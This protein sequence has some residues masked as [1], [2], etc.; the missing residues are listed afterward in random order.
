LLLFEVLTSLSFVSV[1]WVAGIRPS[2]NLPNFQ[3]VAGNPSFAVSKR[4]F[5]TK[6]FSAL[7]VAALGDLGRGDKSPPMNGCCRL[8]GKKRTKI[9][10]V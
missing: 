1:M 2:S 8:L 9:S 3:S 5:A 7:H 10:K 6:V 4:P